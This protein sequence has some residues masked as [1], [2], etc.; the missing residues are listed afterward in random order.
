M[1]LA[2]TLLV[3]VLSEDTAK[4]V[5]LISPQSQLGLFCTVML[6]LTAMQSEK[7][8]VKQEKG[9]GSGHPGPWY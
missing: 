8:N 5:G 4:D 7:L 9:L 6:S 3:K 1:S 2:V